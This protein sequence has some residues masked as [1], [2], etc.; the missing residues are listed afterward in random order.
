MTRR[1]VLFA[2]SVLVLGCSDDSGSDA[3]SAE[4]VIDATSGE[5]AQSVGIQPFSPDTVLLAVNMLHDVKVVLTK[6][7]PQDLDVDVENKDPTTVSTPSSLIK[8]KKWD[9]EQL[10]VIQGLKE[11]SQTVDLVFTIHDTAQTQ[12]LKISVVKQLPD[13]GIPVD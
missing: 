10:M 11:N 7:A 9:T 2:V 12:T 3:S 5:G 4:K 8:F 1:W 6:P 13:A